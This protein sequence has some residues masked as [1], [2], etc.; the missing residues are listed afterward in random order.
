MDALADVNK[1]PGPDLLARQAVV[2]RAARLLRRP[3]ALVRLDEMAAWLAEWQRTDCPVVE[4]PV[5]LLAAGDHG[6]ARRGVSAHGPELTRATVDAV[7][8]GVSTATVMAQSVDASVRLV[9]AGVGEPTGDMTVEPAL[10]ED[11]FEQLIALGRATVEELDTDLLLLGDMGVGSTTAAASLA[12]TLCGGPIT[13][14]VSSEG[15]DEEGYGRR[16]EAVRVARERVG[17]GVEPIEALRQLGGNE[18]AVLA[19]ACLEARIQSIPV[20]LDGFVATAS[21]APLAFAAEN[22]LAHCVASHVSREPG[23]ARLLDRLGMRP[24]LDLGI[25]FGE[26]AGALAALP[27]VRMAAAA[28]VDV[29]TMEEW[30]MR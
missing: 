11:R 22:S 3:G 28:V 26:G 7:R 5:L 29:A 6:V 18:M 9:D 2:D 30:G 10:D 8:A 24:L 23:H 25:D 14:W 27:I 12:A 4:R 13:N 17:T 16:L 1:L 21:V 20:L 19:G 15:V